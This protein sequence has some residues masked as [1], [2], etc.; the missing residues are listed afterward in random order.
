MQVEW[1]RQQAVGPAFWAVMGGFVKTAVLHLPKK[2]LGAVFIE[3]Y[4]LIQ[5]RFS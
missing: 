1:L 3:Q 4:L 5:E 2:V